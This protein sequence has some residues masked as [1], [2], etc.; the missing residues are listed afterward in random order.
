VIRLLEEHLGGAPPSTVA[1]LEGRW[2]EVEED[3]ISLGERVRLLE[4]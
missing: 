3:G 1:N 2:L 4:E